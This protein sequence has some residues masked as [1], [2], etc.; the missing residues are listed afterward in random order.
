MSLG[1]WD[2]KSAQAEADFKIDSQVLQRFIEIS[3]QQL[4]KIDQLLSAEEKQTQAALMQ[5][6][7]SH[8]FSAAESLSDE[9]LVDLMRFF[10][11]AEKLPGWESGDKSPVIW[12]GKVLKKRGTGID[13]DLVLWI[14]ANSSNQFLP[15]GSLL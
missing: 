15:H 2:P 14:K 6:D 3:R 13:R 7:N 8:W 1:S 12:L 9:E 10:T 4:E 5:Q 11:L